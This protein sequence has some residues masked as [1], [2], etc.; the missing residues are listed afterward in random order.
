MNF[1]RLLGNMRRHFIF[2]DCDNNNNYSEIRRDLP[3]QKEIYDTIIQ[4]SNLDCFTE[5]I[6]LNS[7]RREE[8]NLQYHTHDKFQ[9]MIDYVKTDDYYDQEWI[10]EHELSLTMLDY[11]RNREYSEDNYVRLITCIF[12]WC[13]YKDRTYN[14]I[15][16]IIRKIA[17]ECLSGEPN[18]EYMLERLIEL[19]D[20]FAYYPPISEI[21]LI[22]NKRSM[23]KENR[24]I[25]IMKS[26]DSGMGRINPGSLENYKLLMAEAFDLASELNL[27]NVKLELRVIEAID[28]AQMGNYEEFVSFVEKILPEFLHI[29][30]GEQ[31]LDLVFSSRWIHIESAY[32]NKFIEKDFWEGTHKTGILRDIENSSQKK[33]IITILCLLIRAY[34]NSMALGPSSV[35]IRDYISN[36]YQYEGKED[37]T[38]KWYRFIPSYPPSTKFAWILSNWI[39]AIIRELIG[40]EEPDLTVNE[41]PLDSILSELMIPNWPGT[42]TEA[43]LLSNYLDEKELMNK[44]LEM[45]QASEIGKKK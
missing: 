37:P 26:L 1:V 32:F 17:K 40:I 34:P 43:V 36:I 9:K 4:I 7:I 31:E 19:R 39:I 24:I 18:T 25:E 22:E 21:K 20:G 13:F 5:Q 11:F 27:K 41:K 23:K 10:Y 42:L 28:Y 38:Q 35:S 30:V 14:K 15:F 33:L 6:R 16:E 44:A 3:L 45:F 29:E 2:Y 8:H 12:D